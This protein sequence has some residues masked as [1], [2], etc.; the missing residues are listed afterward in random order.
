MSKRRKPPS[1]REKAKELAEREAMFQRFVRATFLLAG[2][3]LVILAALA[4][5]LV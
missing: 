1:K 2:M 5:Y 4:L 3:I